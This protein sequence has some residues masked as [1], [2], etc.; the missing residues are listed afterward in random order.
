[1][2]SCKQLPCK[3]CKREGKTVAKGLCNACYYR[4]KKNGTLEYKVRKKPLAACIVDGC[5]R[6][7]VSR[8]YCDTHHTNNKRFGDPVRNFGY[9]ERSTHPLYQAW[10]YQKRTKE[11]RIPEW[12]DFWAFVNHAVARPS[13]MHTA[14]RYDSSA[15]WGP[16]N[17]YWTERV[18][19]K[20]CAK[21]Y[22]REWR[23]QNPISS[24]N[25][26]LKRAYGIGMIE[27]MQMY[28]QQGGKC[29]ICAVHK[30]SFSSVA[31]RNETLAVD[32]CHDKKHVRALLCSTCNKGLGHF[33]DDIALVQKAA[34]YLKT[35]KR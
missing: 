26:S 35:H 13:D 11:G 22:A 33:S 2:S 24:K 32:H 7:V 27:Y 12:D 17:F 19:S 3:H 4:L 31:G 5:D 6:P 18:A 34:E 23:K 8:E 16:D 21:D 10:D 20:A 15:P 29:A 14:R 30:E 1:M 28:E 9:G 25:S